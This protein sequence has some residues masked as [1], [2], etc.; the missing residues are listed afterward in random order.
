MIIELIKETL[1]DIG[2]LFNAPAINVKEYV[3]GID[4]LTDVRENAK[5][6]FNNK[7]V[8][9]KLSPIN[10]LHYDKEEIMIEL[11]LKVIAEYIVYLV[12]DNR[13][14]YNLFNL[15]GNPNNFNQEYNYLYN[16]LCIYFEVYLG[17]LPKTN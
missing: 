11:I 12:N 9:L 2:E 15:T 4:G 3:Y 7:T 5:L 13:N 6:K 8:Y 10:N 14:R 1:N 17:V 16:T